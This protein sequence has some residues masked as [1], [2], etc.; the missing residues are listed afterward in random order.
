MYLFVQMSNFKIIKLWELLFFFFYL[1]ELQNVMP[2]VNTY[3]FVT[4]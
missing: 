4:I 3:V 1:S 2:F